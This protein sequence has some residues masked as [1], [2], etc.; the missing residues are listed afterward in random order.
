MQKH[1]AAAVRLAS[2]VASAM[3]STDVTATWCSVVG[4][5]HHCARGLARVKV[6]TDSTIQP[7]DRLHT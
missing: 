5:V 7:M 4:A 3:T 1:R 6:W 2:A